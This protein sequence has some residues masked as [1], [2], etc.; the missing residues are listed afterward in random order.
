MLYNHV[1]REPK[2]THI[3]HMRSYAAPGTLTGLAVVEELAHNLVH[4]GSQ[5]PP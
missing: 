3:S 1:L 4:R 5:A 2:Y